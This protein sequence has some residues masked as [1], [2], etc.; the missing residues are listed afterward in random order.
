MLDDRTA[1]TDR[2]PIWDV[3]S[4]AQA[5]RFYVDG[6]PEAPYA[7]PGRRTDLS[8]LPPAWLYAGS[9]ELFYGEIMDYAE[10]LKTAGVPT[11]VS[12]THLTL[13]TKA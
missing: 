8:G 13:P 10:R 12:Y 5:W 2:N 9:S 6:N 1:S 11:P 7:V 3:D 4:N